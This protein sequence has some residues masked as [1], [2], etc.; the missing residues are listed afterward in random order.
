MI[1]KEYTGPIVLEGEFLPE[2]NVFE[3]SV[4]VEGVTYTEKFSRDAFWALCRRATHDF[5]IG[6]LTFAYHQFDKRDIGPRSRRSF[7]NYFEELLA[8]RP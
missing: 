7:V 2:E 6:G 1:G 3:V 4:T 8:R 5:R